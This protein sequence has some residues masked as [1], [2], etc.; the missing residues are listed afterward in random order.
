MLLVTVRVLNSY[1]KSRKGSGLRELAAGRGLHME[2]RTYKLMSATNVPIKITPGHFATNHSHINYYVDTTTLRARQSEAQAAARAL[3]GMYMY[4][5]IVDTILCVDGTQV[6]G[7]YL[8]QELTQAGFMSKN[9]HKTIYIVTPEYNSNSQLIFRDNI[10]PMISGKNVIV[11]LA[12]V[13][14]GKTLAKCVEAIQYYG[15]TVQGVSALFSA[16]EDVC[17]Y[18]I[19]SVF[20]TRDLPDYQSS[21]FI[22][23]PFCKQGKKLDALVNSFGYSKL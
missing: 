5:T 6:I 9:A 15:G 19:N 7:A 11:L 10:R 8:A 21:E 22:D 20:T 16:V 3:K 2:T 4:G 12:D 18:H 1:N 14:S 13:T 17:G 23:C